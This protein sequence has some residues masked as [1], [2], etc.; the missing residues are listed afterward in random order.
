MHN[1]VLSLFFKYSIKLLA[2]SSQPVFFLLSHCRTAAAILL[3]LEGM[4]SGFP[5]ELPCQGTGVF[6]IH[7]LLRDSGNSVDYS[8]V[9][10]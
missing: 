9:L 5:Q 8:K 2:F 7:H 6:I 1:V 3:P 4:G 10:R